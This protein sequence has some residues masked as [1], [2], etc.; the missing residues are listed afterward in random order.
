ME[1]RRWTPQITDESRIPADDGD[2]LAWLLFHQDSVISLSQALRHMSKTIRHRVSSGRWRQ[3][4]RAVVVAHNGPVTQG[5]LWWIGVLAAGPGAVLAG[6]T[7]AQAWGLKRYADGR[8]HV[9]IPAGRR[10]DHI[11]DCV[12]VHRS[13]LLDTRDVLSV[14]TPPRT[15]PPRSLV[16]AAQ[17]A[18]TD[19]EARAVIAAGFQQGLV[20]A[21]DIEKTLDRMRRARRRHLIV[22]TARDAAGGAE[23]L[24]EL[25]FLALV[26]RGG[27]PEPSRQVVRYD[28]SG[29][30]RYL[31]VYYDQWGVHIEIDGGYHLDPRTAWADMQRQNDLWIKGDRVLRFPTW[32]IRQRPYDVLAQV[33]AALRAAGW[34]G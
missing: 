12:V 8:V 31:D 14:G 2:E 19:D 20:A 13:T 9:L 34:S 33:R 6:L 17:W 18:R 29:R 7:A 11:P 10:A 16:D 27:L 21:D 22:L 23:A 26:R 4:H 30:K 24:S 15:M 1:A 5:Q 25:D 32:A 28:A 3:V